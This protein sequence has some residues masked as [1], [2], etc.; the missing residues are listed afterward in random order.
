M[1]AVV[2]TEYGTPDVLVW[3]EVPDPVPGPG[4]IRIRVAAAGVG[5]TDLHIRA[6]HLRGPFPLPTPGILGFEAAGT[7]DALGD[8]VAGVSIGDEVAVLLPQ[9]GGY[10]ELVVADTWVR[11]PDSV[12]WDAAA[13]LPASAEAAVAALRQLEVA[14]GED[15]LLFGGGGSVG[16]IAIQLAVEQGI[17]VLAVGREHSRA[18]VER[19][20]ATF[21]PTAGSLTD[22]VGESTDRVDAVLDA[23]GAVDLTAAVG[24]AGGPA[25]VVTLT[26]AGAKDGVQL[27]HSGPDRAPGALDQT[28]PLLASGMLQLRP[29][30]TYPL[31]DAA[32]AHAALETPGPHDKIVLLHN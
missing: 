21:I 14:P 3:Q 28:M 22:A 17:R 1:R 13:A 10:A 25:R 16:S 32:G 29:R 2:V 26:G 7:V 15:L 9:L 20:G 11:K 8:G 12:S 23:V 5:P 6:G 24:L 19:L 31:H 4:Q 30:V 18:D 27:L